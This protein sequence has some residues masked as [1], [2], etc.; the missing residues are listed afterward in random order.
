[1]TTKFE[2]ASINEIGQR[3]HNEDSIFPNEEIESPLDNLF[4][5]CDG[6][7]GHTKGE[8]ASDLICTQINFYFISK[9]L[10]LQIKIL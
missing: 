2:I 10:K 7:G 8:I 1:M 4:L 9:K 6:V 5:V 3:E